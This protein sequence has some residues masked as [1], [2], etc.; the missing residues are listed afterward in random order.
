[1]QINKIQTRNLVFG[2]IILR[3]EKSFPRE[4]L[5]MIEEKTNARHGGFKAE[6][7][8]DKRLI[9]EVIKFDYNTPRLRDTYKKLVES[10]ESNPVNIYIDLFTADKSEI[11]LHPSGW[12]QKATVGRLTFK[13]PT[14]AYFPMQVN[15]I[16]FLKK[17]CMWANILNF[18]RL[19]K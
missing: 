18:F 6:E 17:A 9:D 16:K 15:P 19:G 11:P 7:L 2:K 5:E 4:F 14:E 13:Q 1:M 12:F 10:Q 8:A 3:D